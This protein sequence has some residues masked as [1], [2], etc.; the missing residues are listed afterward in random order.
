MVTVKQLFI[1]FTI[2][3]ITTIYYFYNQLTS[4]NELNN[5]PKENINYSNY[6]TVGIIDFYTDADFKI[7]QLEETINKICINISNVIVIIFS[8][9][10]IYPPLNYSI[11][12]SSCK[13][14]ERIEKNYKVK[15]YT[16]NQLQNYI[17]T[18]YILF[19]RDM[20]DVKSGF[21][22]FLWSN[23][24]LVDNEIYVMSFDSS[25]KCTSIDFSIVKW[26][27]KFT[28]ENKCEYLNGTSH[29]FLMRKETFLTLPYPLLRPFSQSVFL[30]GKSIGLKFTKYN[31]QKYLN[32][33]RESFQLSFLR[34]EQMY[35]GYLNLMY[36]ELGIK[37]IIDSNGS[38]QLFGCKREEE[39]CFPTIVNDMPYFLYDGKWTP[40]C[41]LEHLRETGRHVFKVLDTYK[42]RYWLEGGSLLGAMR[43]G[44]IIP[45]DTDID[46]G[47]YQEDLE[48]LFIF[49]QV[50]TKG[51]VMDE[52]RYVWEASEESS[53]AG[54]SN[55]LYRV[56]YSATNRIH[57]DI[58]PFYSVNGTMTKDYWFSTHRQD[59]PF[60]ESFLKPTT[61][62]PFIGV[63]ASVPNHPID[64][65]HFKFG[66]DVLD[67]YKLP[68]GTL[69]TDTLPFV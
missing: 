32:N 52:R 7:N 14:I 43:N 54:V 2:V 39:R 53:T 3:Y 34:R 23:L 51:P 61:K 27:L 30:Q 35:K 8:Y 60:P 66:P 12:N 6:L 9:S 16:E 40:P 67:T 36:E 56:H 46:I 20:I 26:T 58:F 4:E 10:L 33:S 29:G 38:I 22:T 13:V 69:V 25:T 1:Y 49:S 50:R 41:C 21:E 15:S 62:V 28:G 47:V 44:D 68:D 63:Q 24:P 59:R 19:I 48:K 64:F 45:W 57:V 42:I 65:L 17:K 37:R 31:V 11:V 55:Y 18:D 5:L